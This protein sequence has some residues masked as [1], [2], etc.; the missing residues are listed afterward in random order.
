MH[1]PTFPTSPLAVI[2]TTIVV[3]TL[4][5]TVV[6]VALVFALLDPMWSRAALALQAVT[7]AV[8]GLARRWGPPRRIAIYALLLAGSTLL[9]DPTLPPT[10]LPDEPVRHLLPL[11]VSVVVLADLLLRR[12]ALS[13]RPARVGVYAGLV[14]LTEAACFFRSDPAWLHGRLTARTARLVD[15]PDGSTLVALEDVLA[16]LQERGPDPGGPGPAQSLRD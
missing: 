1:S 10:E 11:A 9:W 16:V 3:S 2:H 13:F 6:L 7:L 8:M 15:A 4:A 12:D 5:S 14:D